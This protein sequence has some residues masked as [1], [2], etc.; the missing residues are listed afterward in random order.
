MKI[1]QHFYRLSNSPLVFYSVNNAPRNE[2][3][4]QTP[5]TKSEHR[6]N[7]GKHIQV[8]SVHFSYAQKSK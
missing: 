8:L 6:K 4:I 7:V 2:I 1:G 3:I 5:K